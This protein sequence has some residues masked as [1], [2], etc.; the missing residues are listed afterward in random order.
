MSAFTGSVMVVRPPVDEVIPL[1]VTERIL[2]SCPPGAQDVVLEGATHEI[3]RWLEDR[4]RQRRD[5]AKRM[6]QLLS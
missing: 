5:M 2:D 3:Y 4:P 6:A 1:A